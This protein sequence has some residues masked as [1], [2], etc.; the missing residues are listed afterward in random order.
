[1]FERMLGWCENGEKYKNVS[2]YW[3]QNIAILI[4]MVDF[5]LLQC[6]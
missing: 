4:P 1:M 6:Y 3:R 5:A 2:F